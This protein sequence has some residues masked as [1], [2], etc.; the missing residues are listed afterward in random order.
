MPPTFTSATGVELY[1]ADGIKGSNPCQLEL[2]FT[3]EDIKSR[4]KQTYWQ[5]SLYVL[6]ALGKLVALILQTNNLTGG[7]PAS[8][9]NISSLGIFSV[10]YNN[11]VG[12]IPHELGRLKSL[13][14]LAIGPNNLFG[15][16]PFPLYNMSS[17]STFSIAFNQI[18]G[19]LPSNIGLMLP[20]LK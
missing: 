17:M 6:G 11:L 7:I 9:G 4:I 3:A 1:V 2:L 5:D 18:N 8:L 16:I 14:F 19:T 13:T 12:S 10:A 20:N 15:T